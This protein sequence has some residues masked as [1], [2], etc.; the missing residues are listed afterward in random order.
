MATFSHWFRLHLEHG[1]SPS[2]TQP[3]LSHQALDK[4]TRTLSV[5]L[6]PR[7]KS[8]SLDQERDKPAYK[9]LHPSRH[10]TC[11]RLGLPSPAPLSPKSD[12]EGRLVQGCAER[13]APYSKAKGRKEDYKNKGYLYARTRGT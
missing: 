6:L 1:A 2:R 9:D 3:Q 13:G 8:G 4:S 5:S 11:R 10:Q 12:K 7:L